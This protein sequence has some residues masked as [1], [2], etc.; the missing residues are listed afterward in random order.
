[1]LS[2][3]QLKVG[4]DN[5][6]RQDYDTVRPLSRSAYEAVQCLLSE[7][8]V[9]TPES[10]L[11]IL[12]P[13]EIRDYQAGETAAMMTIFFEALASYPK[14]SDVHRAIQELGYRTENEG[15]R[16]EVMNT[17][18]QVLKQT[19]EAGTDSELRRRQV[20]DSLKN[21]IQEVLDDTKTK[22]LDSDYTE[23]QIVEATNSAITFVK[24]V[25]RKNHFYFDTWN[26]EYE[27]LRLSH[28]LEAVIIDIV[29]A[30][31]TEMQNQIS[32]LMAHTKMDEQEVKR[33]LN[34]Y[35]IATLNW[36]ETEQTG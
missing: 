14:P 27:E 9:L 11:A 25:A 24:D 16:R 5:A 18:L 1:M 28:L 3:E 30:I 15:R 6:L 19:I 20:I 13:E 26:I 31:E 7:R 8:V 12:T 32:Y 29:R 36:M 17:V 10:I 23:S 34:E 35:L 2:N 22:L 4:V 33:T 21:A